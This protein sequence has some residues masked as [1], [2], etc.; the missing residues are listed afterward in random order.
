MACRGGDDT[1]RVLAVCCQLHLRALY[2][3]ELLSLVI[4]SEEAVRTRKSEGLS[5][6]SFPPFTLEPN[7]VFL[8]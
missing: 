6:H 8:Q 3:Q 2:A 7:M 1:Y 5:A 4:T